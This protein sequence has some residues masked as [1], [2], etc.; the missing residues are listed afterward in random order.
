MAEPLHNP[1]P[2]FEKNLRVYLRRL[3]LRL[4]Q[5]A[6]LVMN[7]NFDRGGYETESGSFVRWKPRK[8]S[9]W[10]IKSDE[11]RALL[12][13]TGRLRR[14][15]KADPLMDGTP[16]VITDVPYADAH[17]NGFSGRVTQKV[18]SY[19]RSVNGKLGVIKT[20]SLKKSTRISFGTAK[21]GQ[22]KV[23]AYTRTINQNIP[24]RPFMQVGKS[25]LDAEEKDLLNSLENLF[26]QS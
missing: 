1:F 4:S 14:S 23:K 24:Q 8:K 21:V 19:N 11:G 12:I 6:L 22:R 25:F 5:R 3:P 13:Q 10:K 7:S 17:Q 15:L 9:T 2:A 18:G 20:T 26:L 16:R